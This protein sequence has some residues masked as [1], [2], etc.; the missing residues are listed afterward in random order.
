MQLLM[1]CGRDR[2]KKLW[3]QG[4]ERWHDLVTL[5]MSPDVQPDFVVDLP[6]QLPFPDDSAEEMHFYDVLE[7]T[8]DQ[9]DWTGFFREFSEYWR[10]LRP[11]GHLFGICPA[12]SGKWAWGDPGHRRVIQPETLTFLSQAIY[13]EELDGPE[14]TNRTDYRA[15]YRADFDLMQVV[16]MPGPCIGFVL[17]AVKPTRWR[18][19]S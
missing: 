2:S 14:R 3:L 13:A 19:P 10:V 7:H 6:G 15:W 11:G 12:W 8:G 18:P 17:R 4:K 16:D 9:G 1:G 5:D